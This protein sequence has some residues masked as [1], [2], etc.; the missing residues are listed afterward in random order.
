MNLINL[1]LNLKQTLMKKIYSFIS[2]LTFSTFLCNAQIG[3]KTDNPLGLLHI[4]PLENT[5]SQI[6]QSINDDIIINN[7]GNLGLGILKPETKV[8]I[9]TSLTKDTP[10][11][12]LRINDGN[13]HDSYVLTSDANG[14]ATWRDMTSM[15]TATATRVGNVVPS[16]GTTYINLNTYIELPI[17]RWLVTPTILI[18]P[19]QRN[20]WDVQDKVWMYSSFTENTALILQTSDI[21]IDIEDGAFTGGL[22]TKTSFN[23]LTGSFVINNSSSATKTYYLMLGGSEQ[24]GD[25]IAS[26]NFGSVN[27]PTGGPKNGENSVVAVLIQD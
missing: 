5:N 24:I 13:E 12:G 25:L 21:S 7:D 18:S 15:P 16:Q 27:F 6:D 2:I 17:G 9:V 8:H 23:I 26:T 22:I 19:P 10:N 3:I 14:Y 4:D 1:F 11:I 20:N